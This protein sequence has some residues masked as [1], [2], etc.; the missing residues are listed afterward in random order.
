MTAAIK[1]GPRSRDGAERVEVPLA[2]RGEFCLSSRMFKRDR[3]RTMATVSRRTA[4][5]GGLA[6]SM[7]AAA[8]SLRAQEKLRIRVSSLTLPV[9][10]PIV[11]NIM[12]ERGFD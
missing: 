5:G 12:K 8:P 10:N 7:I 9:F 1:A 4:L 11:W 3:E 6:A 2:R